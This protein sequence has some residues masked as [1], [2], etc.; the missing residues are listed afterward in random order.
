MISRIALLFLL[1]PYSCSFA[2]VSDSDMEKMKL[3]WRAELKKQA[4]EQFSES[5]AQE[6][7]STFSDSI[8][9]LFSADT[10]VVEKLLEKQLQQDPSTLGMNKANLA[11]A[12]EYEQLVEK[13]YAVLLAKMRDE[14][15]ELLVSWQS[16]WKALMEKERPLIGKLMQ[17]EYSGGGSIQSLNYT[18]RLLNEQKAHLLVI[19]DYLMHLI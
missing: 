9:R 17:E 2:Q 6:G 7:M 4:H 11:C 12:S 10:F 18:S 3:N 5:P 13:Y 8:S 1:F 14:D 15:R 16:S 19:I